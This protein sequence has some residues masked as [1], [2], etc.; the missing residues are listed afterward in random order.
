M[1]HA[2]GLDDVIEVDLSTSEDEVFEEEYQHDDLESEHPSLQADW[3][4]LSTAERSDALRAYS[5]SQQIAR[6]KARRMDMADRLSRE[7][8]DWTLKPRSI[9]A[10]TASTSLAVGDVFSTRQQFQL[11]VA[12][13]C[14]WLHK[15]P[16]WSGLSSDPAKR[17]AGISAGYA[18]ARSWSSDDNFVVK[19]VLKAEGWTVVMADLSQGSTRQSADAAGHR[20]S[21]FTAKQLAPVIL[22]LI[23]HDPALKAAMIRASL[24]DFVR[25]DCI[26]DALIQNIREHARLA[27]FGDPVHNI[28]FMQ[29]LVDL[30]IESGHRAKLVSVNRLEAKALV[31]RMAYWEH[32]QKHSKKPPE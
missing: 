1:G 13:L 30:T 11:R 28:Q 5:S 31:V 21:P 14:H 26:S 27:V 10:V 23:R 7:G 2:I 6:S 32:K 25:V 20:K 24:S 29:N 15:I 16:R 19:A 3:N 18:C 12:E 4:S 8:F 22:P 17:R 9:A